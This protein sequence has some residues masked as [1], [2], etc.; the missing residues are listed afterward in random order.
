MDFDYLNVS[1][2]RFNPSRTQLHKNMSITSEER[3]ALERLIEAG[4]EVWM[5][6]TCRDP[7]VLVSELLAAH[8]A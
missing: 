6:P 5:Q 8:P 7:K 3:A 1:G 2:M 4:V